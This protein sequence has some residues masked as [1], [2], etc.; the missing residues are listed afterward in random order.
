MP[1]HRTADAAGLLVCHE[2]GLL[3]RRPALHEHGRCPRCRAPLH[4]RK[5]H[6]LGRTWALL[7]ASVL[8]YVPANLL[9]VMSVVSLGRSQSDT[10]LS[11]VIH[12]LGA[13]MWPLALLVFFA[14]ILVPL[15]KLGVLA[16][17]LVSVQRRSHW[18]PRD[19]AR[20]FRLTELVGRWSMV[21]I[22]VITLLAALVQL[23]ELAYIQAGAGATAFGAVV[24]L[25]MFAAHTFDPRLIWDAMDDARPA[26]PVQS[27]TG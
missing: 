9:P 3:S 4:R 8:L 24:V 2:C 23:G 1:E 12:L 7:I 10:I 27:Q 26:I 19:R 21:D 22:F 18:R 13:G 17:L 6:S 20:L 25:T 15:L 14:S 11:G 16:F 5:P